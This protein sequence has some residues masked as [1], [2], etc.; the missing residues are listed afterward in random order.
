MVLVDQDEAALMARYDC[1]LHMITAAD[2]AEAHYTLENNATR[3]EG[4]STPARAEIRTCTA[5]T[6]FAAVTVH[7]STLPLTM[8]P[9]RRGT[10]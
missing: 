8:Q 2:G 3:T 7:A 5:A 4:D 9:H 1:V 6:K 10:G